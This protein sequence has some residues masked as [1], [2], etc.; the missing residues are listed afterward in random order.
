MHAIWCDFYHQHEKKKKCSP[1]CLTAVKAITRYNAPRRLREPDWMHFFFLPTLSWFLPLWHSVQLPIGKEC[2]CYNA[3]CWILHH[4]ADKEAHTEPKGCNGNA[5]VPHDAR[6][7]A[8]IETRK[9]NHLHCTG[10]WRLLRASS[11]HQILNRCVCGV[12]YFFV[13]LVW[14]AFWGKKS[15]WFIER[16]PTKYTHKKMSV[17]CTTV[18]HDYDS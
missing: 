11:F 3:A 9:S 17:W 10:E 6:T 13:F 16:I 14:K 7:V 1:P 5:P 2:H 8:G 12:V 15:D 18:L 4:C